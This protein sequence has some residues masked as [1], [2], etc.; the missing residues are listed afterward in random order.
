MNFWAQDEVSEVRTTGGKA[1]NVW[2]RGMELP[3]DANTANKWHPPFALTVVLIMLL[4]DVAVLALG[5]AWL[6]SNH[7]Q[8]Q[9]RAMVTTQNF[10]RLLE[11]SI[12]D[13]IDRTELSLHAVS[14]EIMRQPGALG[15]EDS[16]LNAFI[17]RQ[18]ARI[19]D[20]EDILVSNDRGDILHS[21]DSSGKQNISDAAPFAYHRDHPQAGTLISKP[22]FNEFSRKWTIEVSRRYI[23]RNGL[24]GGLV[25]G[26]INLEYFELM[27]SSLNVGA[28]GMIG[29]RDESLG[30]VVRYPKLAERDDVIGNNQISQA[31][32]NLLKAQP[33]KGTFVGRSELDGI[34]RIYSYQKVGKWPLY[35]Q[36]GVATEDVFAEWRETMKSSALFAALF[37]MLSMVLALAASHFSQVRRRHYFELEQNRQ[38]FRALAE[39][40]SDWFWEQD[41]DYRF[42]GVTD[43]LGRKY[44]VSGENYE[45]KTRM[46]IAVDM[47]AER[48]GEHLAALDAHQPFYDFEYCV[49][50]DQG[51][52]RTISVS[53]EPVFDERGDFQ[54]YRGVGQD[55]TDRKRYEERIE[56]MAQYDILTN[57]PNRVL[58]YDRL[59]Q[60]MQRARRDQHELALLYFDLD[61]FKPVNDEYGHAAGDQL[62]RQVAWRVRGLLRESDTVAR[63][64]GDEFAALLPRVNCRHDAEEVAQKIIATLMDPFVLDN[65]GKDVFIGVSIGIA[66]FP[67]DADNEDCLI[68]NAD[69]A[70]YRAKQIRNCYHF[71]SD[72]KSSRE[73]GAAGNGVKDRNHNG[74][75]PHHDRQTE[76]T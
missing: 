28:R 13:S 51:N 14:D 2:G 52:K 73:H 56:H 22:R 70:M 21:A 61:K 3:R 43:D 23:R 31:Y 69:A 27:F 67:H 76:A 65:V 26:T 74:Q 34:E 10:A 36:V 32:Q 41:K 47:N 9:E 33:Y 4:V 38:K 19:P 46:E 72:A 49:L 29:L 60:A 8:Y 6:R 17:A 59:K 50:D 15:P 64:G 48:W 62:L 7:R 55:I 71:F 11:Q 30:I 35:V 75:L 1:G 45:G 42:V 37:V 58:F 25:I 18:H 57:L 66:I 12:A 53:G 24:F 44:G 63:L 54:G 16:D 5:Y 68:K 39:L 40:S 20:L